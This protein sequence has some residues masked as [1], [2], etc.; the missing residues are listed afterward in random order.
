MKTHR[1]D[2]KRRG[3]EAINQKVYHCKACNVY[4][5][6]QQQLNRHYLSKSHHALIGK[7]I[8]KAQHT[9]LMLHKCD[10]CVVGFT[11]KSDLERHLKTKSHK[12][13]IAS[14]ANSDAPHSCQP[15]HFFAIG[16]TRY[17]LN[18]GAWENGRARE[19]NGAA[20]E[21]WC[22]VGHKIFLSSVRVRDEYS[23]RF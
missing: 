19:E 1:E 18:W 13:K 12:S 2:I 7:P 21:K 11:S 10:T 22:L 15:Y 8:S 14:T 6:Q 4:F 9:A 5:S 16:R 23:I 3:E 20:G 17:D